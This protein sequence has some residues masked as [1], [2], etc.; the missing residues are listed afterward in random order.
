MTIA[1][2]LIALLMMFGSSCAEEMPVTARYL[3][4]DCPAQTFDAGRIIDL[5]LPTPDP[6]PNPQ[7][8]PADPRIDLNTAT[9]SELESLPGVGPALAGRIIEYRAK[10]RFERK[11]QLRRVRGIGPATY[12]KLKHLVMVQGEEE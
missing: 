9:R 11:A 7:P 5:E 12:A 4:A 2:P 8:Q 10:R 1:Q 6:R 3:P